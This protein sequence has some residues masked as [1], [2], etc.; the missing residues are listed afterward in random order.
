MARE[1]EKKKL[2]LINVQCEQSPAVY[3][4]VTFNPPAES[5]TSRTGSFT[6]HLDTYTLLQSLAFFFSHFSP[7]HRGRALP[8]RRVALYTRCEK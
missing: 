4:T 6:T 2:K 1:Y 8:T 3:T 5:T 7:S